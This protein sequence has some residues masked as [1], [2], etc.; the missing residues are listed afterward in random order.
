MPGREDF[1]RDE[2]ILVEDENEADL[3]EPPRYRVI[4]HNDDYTTMEFVIEVLLTVF[5]R[6]AQDA[7]RLMLQVHTLGMA[8]GGIYPYEIAEAKVDR[9]TQLARARE[10]PFQLTKFGG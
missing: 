5:H 2:D 3:E 4:L 1:E 6:S 9:V 10:F 8:V 7:H